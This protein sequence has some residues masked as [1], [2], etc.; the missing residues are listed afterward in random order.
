MMRSFNEQV[1]VDESGIGR[2][3]RNN[4]RYVIISPCRNEAAYI[5]KTLDSVVQQTVPPVQWIIVDDGSTDETPEILSEYASRFDYIK[6]VRR[7]DRGARSVG[8]G[9][10]QAFYDGYEQ[11]DVPYTYLC[12]LDMDLDLPHRYF[13]RLMELMEL[14]PRLGTASGKAFYVEPNTGKQVL[15]QIRDHVSLGMTKFYRRECFEQI[16]GFVREVMWD[17]IDCHR[18]RMLGWIAASYD[19]LELRFE[20][21][22][23]MGSS[24]KDIHKG[25]RRHGYGQYFMG[26]SLTFMTASALSRL[27]AKP[28]IIGALMMWWG[29]VDAMLHRRPR[30]EDLEFIRFLRRWQWLS[31]FKGTQRATEQINAERKHLWNPA[32]D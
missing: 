9:V 19:E 32:A 24:E 7:T 22:R 18:A 23:P 26:T 15:E 31:L 2:S 6:I 27:F 8:P 11:I 30:Y 29:Y 20:H 4:R 25:R 5:R 13:E 17:G 14:E 21:L 12:K 3:M 16:G 10:I 1:C 28:P